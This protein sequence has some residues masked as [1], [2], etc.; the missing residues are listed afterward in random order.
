[1]GIEIPPAPAPAGPEEVPE[2]GEPL[3]PTTAAVLAAIKHAEEVLQKADKK[4]EAGEA[5]LEEFEKEVAMLVLARSEVD[6]EDE[7]DYEGPNG[8]LV[9][10]REQEVADLLWQ[11]GIDTNEAANN[12]DAEAG[13]AHTCLLT[14]QTWCRL[15]W[16]VGIPVRQGSCHD[17]LLRLRRQLDTTATFPDGVGLTPRNLAK[18]LSQDVTLDHTPSEA[19]PF[20]DTGLFPLRSKIV[21]EILKRRVECYREEVT[22]GARGEESV[23]ASQRP[24]RPSPETMECRVVLTSAGLEGHRRYRMLEGSGNPGDDTKSGIGEGIS[25]GAGRNP[26]SGSS[27]GPPSSSNRLRM[28]ATLCEAGPAWL[29]LERPEGVDGAIMAELTVARQTTAI[30]GLVE[31]LLIH[32]R[33]K[34]RVMFLREALNR[35]FPGTNWGKPAA[36][37]TREHEDQAASKQEEGGSPLSNLRRTASSLG[38][39]N[40]MAVFGEPGVP[41]SR[42]EDKAEEAS[43]ARPQPG[44]A[45]EPDG[46]LSPSVAAE[47]SPSESLGGG[48]GGVSLSREDLDALVVDL[49]SSELELWSLGELRQKEDLLVSSRARASKAVERFMIKHGL[50]PDKQKEYGQMDIVV[51]SVDGVVECER[52]LEMRHDRRAVEVKKLTR[53]G[54]DEAEKSLFRNIDIDQSGTLSRDEWVVHQ[55]EV[56]KASLA[57]REVAAEEEEIEEDDGVAEAQEVSASAE[58]NDTEGD[59]VAEMTDAGPLEEEIVPEV[60]EDPY[61]IQLE[62]P[63]QLD[64]TAFMRQRAAL[65]R[66]IAKRLHAEDPPPEAEAVKEAQTKVKDAAAMWVGAESERSALKSLRALDKLLQHALPVQELPESLESNAIYLIPP[67]QAVEEVD[68]G[69]HR[70]RGVSLWYPNPFDGLARWRA[71][72]STFSHPLPPPDRSCPVPSRLSRGHNPLTLGCMRGVFESIGTLPKAAFWGAK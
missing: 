46:K 29:E 21:E 10:V 40:A 27:V 7:D 60:S 70:L 37:S 53:G 14:P 65:A 63:E 42:V 51:E 44:E 26:S 15:Q 11:I 57:E 23:Q 36:G 30:D 47:L 1:L 28:H 31:L 13:S 2:T 64:V 49:V 50:D 62:F 55:K 43:F 41:S 16:W 4:V 71:P 18:W 35:R 19:D 38:K 12:D 5:K 52:L 25:S 24:L 59:A 8:K 3:D 58:E 20:F 45:N 54:D 61:Q 17:S 9:V 56:D 72:R 39:V 22:T 66:R 68:R 69:T 33:T 67:E 34:E 32:A 6:S 48:G